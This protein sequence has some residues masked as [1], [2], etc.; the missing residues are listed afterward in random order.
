MKK[1]IALILMLAMLLPIQTSFAENDSVNV[2]VNGT[3]IEFEVPPVIE[4]GVTLV[5]VRELA[6]ALN[7][8]IRWD[9]P[10]FDAPANVKV[11]KKSDIGFKC[12]GF[13]IG[14]NI[15]RIRKHLPILITKS[16]TLILCT[17]YTMICITR[18]VVHSLYACHITAE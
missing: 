3:K 16:L 6:E 13:V 10:A 12:I 1:I 11:I 2:I 8:E 17:S 18:T 4:N 7:T 14:S 5:P 15:R 9:V